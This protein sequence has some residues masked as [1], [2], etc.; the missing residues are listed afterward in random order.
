MFA[1]KTAIVSALSRPSAFRKAE[2][3]KVGM[4]SMIEIKTRAGFAH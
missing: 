2:N 1:L 3:F 4:D